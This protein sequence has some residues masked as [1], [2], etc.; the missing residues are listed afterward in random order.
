MNA[1]TLIPDFNVS[2]GCYKLVPFGSEEFTFVSCCDEYVCMIE[3][4]FVL[5][6]IEDRKGFKE[7]VMCPKFRKARNE[8]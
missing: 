6:K 1:A 8:K 3:P 5:E 7:W 2:L 4:R